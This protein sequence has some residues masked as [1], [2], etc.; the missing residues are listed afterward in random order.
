MNSFCHQSCCRLF[1]A[2]GSGREVSPNS[3]QYYYIVVVGIIIQAADV[4]IHVNI[5]GIGNISGFIGE[6]LKMVLSLDYLNLLPTTRR[7]A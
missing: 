2:D 3:Q 4:L 7:Y 1:I 5:S 6:L